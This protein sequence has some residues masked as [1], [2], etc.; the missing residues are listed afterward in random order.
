LAEA[1][2]DQQLSLAIEESADSDNT[3]IT[4]SEAWSWTSVP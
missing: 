2:Q 4:S 1:A 3:V